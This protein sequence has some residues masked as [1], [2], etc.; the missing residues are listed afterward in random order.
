MY[1]GKEPWMVNGIFF[2][3]GVGGKGTLDTVSLL[4]F[5]I[6]AGGGMLIACSPTDQLTDCDCRK[7]FR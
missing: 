1:T 5:C 4:F 2:L 3:G 7:T 6:R